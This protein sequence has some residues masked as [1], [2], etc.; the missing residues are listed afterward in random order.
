MKIHETHKVTPLPTGKLVCLECE[1][2]ELVQLVRV[3]WANLKPPTHEEVLEEVATRSG[4]TIKACEELLELGW[5]YIETLNGTP[6]W[7]LSR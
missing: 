5:T 6:R 2:S 7:E 4:L 1:A 3:C